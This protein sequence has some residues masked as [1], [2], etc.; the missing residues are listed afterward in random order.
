MKKLTTPLLASVTLLVALFAP[1]AGS[2]A[3]A[4]I[5]RAAAQLAATGTVSLR[6]AGAYV[7]PGT[8]RIQVSTQ[9]GRPSTRLADGTWLY[10]GH[11]IAESHATGTLVVRFKDGRVS[12]LSLVTEARALALRETTQADRIA[13]KE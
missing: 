9:L 13:Q 3:E 2:A 4:P 6:Q 10:E 12:Q 7:S 8:P 11:R 5:D 1:V